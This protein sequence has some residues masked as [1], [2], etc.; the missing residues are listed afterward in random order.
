MTISATEV[1]FDDDSIWV[2]LSDGR[3]IGVPFAWFPRLL[4]ATR[5]QRENVEIGRFGLHWAEIDEDISIAGLL[6]GRGDRTVDAS[7]AIKGVAPRA[8]KSSQPGDSKR[9]A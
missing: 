7:G 9:R 4:N 8:R 6:A 5:K 2:D 3:T 1:R